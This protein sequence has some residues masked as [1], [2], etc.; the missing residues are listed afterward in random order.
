VTTKQP[1]GTAEMVPVAPGDGAGEQHVAGVGLGLS[2]AGTGIGAG[3]GGKGMELPDG[4]TCAGNGGVGLGLRQ[5]VEEDEV[6][7][8]DKETIVPQSGATGGQGSES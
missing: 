8:G 5:V 2:G 6:P 7:V 3:G 1:E 4:A